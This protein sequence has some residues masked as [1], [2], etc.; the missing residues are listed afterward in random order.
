M[1][2][3]R[4]KSVNFKYDFDKQQLNTQILK[5]RIDK[6]LEVLKLLSRT[7]LQWRIK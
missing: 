1:K 5:E 4:T 2:N 3:S 7:S 6:C